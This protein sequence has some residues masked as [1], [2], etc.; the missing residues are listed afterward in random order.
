MRRKRRMARSRRY[1]FWPRHAALAA[2]VLLIAGCRNRAAGRIVDIG[3]GLWLHIHCV[4]EGA[5]TVI[6][7]SGLGSDG[8]VWSS[9]EPEIARFARVCD[10]DRAGLGSSSPAPRP[11]GNRQMARELHELLKRAAVPGPYVL[12]GHSMGGTN[13][14]LFASEF[15]SEVSGLVLVD[16]PTGDEWARSFALRP[17]PAREEFKAGL[18]KIPEGIDLDTM[19][20]GLADAEASSRSIDSLPLIVLT[21]GRDPA[22]LSPGVSADNAAEMSK[23]HLENQVKLSRLSSNSAQIT[24]ESSRHFIQLDAPRLVVGAVHEVVDAARNH[25]QVNATAVSSQAKQG[26]P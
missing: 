10:S 9:V 6:L 13:V 12:V 8:T 17:E 5:P 2:L 14:R 3:G 18:L 22:A 1:V 23:G 4:G 25:R 7:E 19:M 11:H 21:R 26:M 16:V 15:P 24:A 20:A